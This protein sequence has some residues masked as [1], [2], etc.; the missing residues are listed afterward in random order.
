MAETELKPIPPSSPEVETSFELRKRLRTEAYLNNAAAFYDGEQILKRNADI[1]AE[2]ITTRLQEKGYTID[3]DTAKTFIDQAIGQ[4]EYLRESLT[5]L[6]ERFPGASSDGAALFEYLT[7]HAPK[8]EAS[9]NTDN[10]LAWELLVPDHADSNALLQGANGQYNQDWR[11]AQG[12]KFLVSPWLPLGVANNRNSMLHEVGGHGTNDYFRD[13]LPR[14][15]RHKN[16]GSKPA[17]RIWGNYSAVDFDSPPGPEHSDVSTLNEAYSL[18]KNE[19]LAEYATGNNLTSHLL[20]LVSKGG[21]YDYLEPMNRPGREMA[22]EKARQEYVRTIVEATED[23]Q[24]I[25]TAYSNGIGRSRKTLLP[26]VLRQIPLQKWHLELGNKTEILEE[27]RLLRQIESWIHT[28]QDSSLQDEY[29]EIIQIARAN[30]ALR[31][32][33]LLKKFN[34]RIA[35][36]GEHLPE[37]EDMARQQFSVQSNSAITAYQQIGSDIIKK[38][39]G[40]PALDR[41]YRK[42]CKQWGVAPS[43]TQLEAWLSPSHQ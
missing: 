19:I 32:M 36:K 5:A 6:R 23:L 31:L 20:S 27:A 42:T 24:F 8:G 1:S 28:T 18:A 38:S 40:L 9:L 14:A 22:Y 2:D 30:R 7:G 29:E 43:S 11:P 41:D 13:T 4:R 12:Q 25:D 26:W 39:Q 16:S 35:A 21:G 34:E 33:P 17:R 10:P 37:K 3:H 15:I